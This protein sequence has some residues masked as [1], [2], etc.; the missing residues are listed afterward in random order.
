MTLRQLELFVAVAETKS[1]SRGAELVCLTQSTVS[2]HIAAMEAEVD[3]RLF[4]RT[5]KGIF[6][7]A[8]GEV[9]LSHARRILAEYRALYN[10]METFHG[11]ESATLVL[12][13]SN[14][15]ANYLIPKIL[16]LLQSEYPG[17]RLDMRSGDSREMTDLLVAGQIEM[18][19][20]GGQMD[21]E[22][23]NYRSLMEDHLV[24]IVGQDS[25]L[26][27]RNTIPLAELGAL[28]LIVRESGSGTFQTLENQLYAAG[29]PA[30]SLTIVARLGSNEAIRQ[31]VAAGCGCAFVSDLSIA[32]ELERGDLFKL[33][34]EGLSIVR[35]LWLA[36][37]KDRTLSPAV[38][39]LSLLLRKRYS[40]ASA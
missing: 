4:D 19:I 26:R 3:T 1:F 28:P 34:I 9:F 31:A 2:Q 12:G 33:E 27:E 24:L 40:L 18:A 22:R 13:A 14:I 23:V 35:Q 15:P 10:G 29:F 8:G 36:T 6:L 17:I 21:P 25:P 30:E 11:L 38:E 5:S 16:P 37:L 20:V 39:A 7:T 32:R